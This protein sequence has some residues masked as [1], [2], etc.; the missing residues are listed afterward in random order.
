MSSPDDRDAQKSSRRRYPRPAFGD[1]VV[2]HGRHSGVDRCSI[3]RV[4]IGTGGDEVTPFLADFENLEDAQPAA[5]SGAPA[6]LAADGVKDPLA[7]LQAERVEAR[8]SSE[9]GRS[10]APLR[11]ATLAE[12]ADEALGDHR[13]QS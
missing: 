11:L 13:A 10:Q 5:I 9:I 8:I 2:D 12:L 4:G 1:A 6:S 7:C 3:D